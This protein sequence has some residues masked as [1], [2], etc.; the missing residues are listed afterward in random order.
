[1]RDGEMPDAGDATPSAAAEGA[2]H[3]HEKREGLNIRPQLLRLAPQYRRLRDAI[4]RPQLRLTESRYFWERW[5][6]RLG[7]DATVLIMDVRDRC[8]RAIAAAAAPHTLEQPAGYGAHTELASEIP[9]DECTVSANELAAACGFSRVTLW[10]ILQREDVRRFIRVEHNYVYDRRLGKKRRTVSTYHVLMEDPLIEEDEL[11]LQQ[12]V[13]SAAVDGAAI[14]NVAGA[15]GAAGRQAG[16]PRPTSQFETE[17]VDNRPPTLHLETNKGGSISKPQDVPETIYK[18]RLG[19]NGV[20]NV[21]TSP[22]PSAAAP[23][24][25][26]VPE[27]DLWSKYPELAHYVEEAETTL[28]DA[29]SRGFYIKA[30][31][32]LYPGHMGIWQRALGFAREQ[33]HIRRSRGALFTRLLRTFA[34]EAGVQL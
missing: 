34:A 8:N 7:P 4:L 33:Q 27:V 22:P 29:H 13:E 3:G 19:A 26:A 17:V 28:G 11:R 6:P 23:R 2:A 18:E 25:R 24:R 5:K 10:R 9:A 21:E 32:A 12:L 20:G 1:M 15:T 16:Y 14:E 31:K 30:L